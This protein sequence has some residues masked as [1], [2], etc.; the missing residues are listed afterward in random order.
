MK[1]RAVAASIAVAAFALVAPAPFALAGGGPSQSPTPTRA[2][3][4]SPL[5]Q[6][7]AQQEERTR[8][9]E[10]AMEDM[11]TDYSSISATLAATYASGATEG[12]QSYVAATQGLLSQLG[13]PDAGV[14]TL[15]LPEESDLAASSVADLNELAVAS[16][17][18]ID[19]SNFDDLGAAISEMRENSSSLDASVTAAG[20]LWGEQMMSLRAPSLKTPSVP[21]VSSSYATDFPREGLVFGMFMNRSINKLISNFPKVFKEVTGTGIKS[22]KAKAAWNASVVAAARSSATDLKRM[23]PGECGEDFVA[24]LA[25]ERREGGCTPCSASGV[26]AHSQLVT[27]GPFA[28]PSSARPATTSSGQG[29]VDAALSRVDDE[30]LCSAAAPAVAEAAG[31]AAARVVRSLR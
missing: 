4:A 13:L 28:T 25:G 20:A 9:I 14:R 10:Q 5:D 17:A 21:Q 8:L 2:T 1:N 29:S 12:K 30:S 11:G 22:T 15:D 23:V 26:Y 31:E 24:G 16:G 18:G 27:A 7:W 3:L 6:Q 19:Y